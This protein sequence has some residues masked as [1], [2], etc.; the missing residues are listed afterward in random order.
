MPK[1]MVIDDEPFILMMI[2]DKLRRAGIDVVT[3]RESVGAVEKIREEMPDL[4]ILDWMMPEIS[5]IEIC[6]TI[7]SDP[8]LSDIPVFMLTA[9]GQEDDEKLGLKCGVDRYITKPFSPRG[10][11]E[12]VLENLRDRET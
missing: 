9:K 7:K 1:V 12:V 2:E 11:L 8:D 6:K 3:L 4:I 5:G 10:L